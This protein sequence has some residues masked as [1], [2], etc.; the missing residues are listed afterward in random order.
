MTNK[1]R[2]SYFIKSLFKNKLYSLLQIIALFAITSRTIF[3]VGPFF[4]P[5]RLNGERYLQFLRQDLPMLLEEF[6]LNRRRTMLYQHDGATPYSTNAVRNYLNEVFPDRW[7]GRN[8]PILWP[9]RSPDL[10]PLDYFL[11]GHI[12]GIVYST[13]VRDQEECHQRILRAF[14]S[15]DEDM[16]RRATTNFRRRAQVLLEQNGRHFEHLL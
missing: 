14:E 4:L 9:A 5:P 12:K 6:P 8:G 10:T 2:F 1:N 3:Q 16:V 7:I 13:T 11:W 15:V